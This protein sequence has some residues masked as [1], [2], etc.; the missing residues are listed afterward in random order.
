MRVSKEQVFH[1]AGFGLITALFNTLLRSDPAVKG[2]AGSECGSKSSPIILIVI[3]DLCTNRA[4]V[5]AADLATKTPPQKIQIRGKH[6][7]VLM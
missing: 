2:R 7:Y 1:H 3:M 5:R 4:G 6:H